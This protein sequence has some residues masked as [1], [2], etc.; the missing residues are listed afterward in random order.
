MNDSQFMIWMRSGQNLS[1]ILSSVSLNET[2][3]EHFQLWD[4]RQVSLS[5]FE[6]KSWLDQD[7]YYFGIE[8]W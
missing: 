1:N 2:P 5:V 6:G 4:P 3:T 8:D 7:P